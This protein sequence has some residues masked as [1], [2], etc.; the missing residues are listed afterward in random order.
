MYGVCQ[1]EPAAEWTAAWLTLGQRSEES[2]AMTTMVG[3]GQKFQISMLERGKDS[4]AA[5]VVEQRRDA[6]MHS[7]EAPNPSEFFDDRDP[8]WYELTHAQINDGELA[9]VNLIRERVG[10]SAPINRSPQQ[11][12][13][14]E[15]VDQ[16]AE[17]LAGNNR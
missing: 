7:L 14:D 1:S 2:S 6:L 9:A 8:F 15:L 11:R 4:E 5:R 12:S 10:D 16:V 13:R 17:G 3:I